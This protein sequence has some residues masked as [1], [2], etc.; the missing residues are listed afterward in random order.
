M[1]ENVFNSWR[2]AAGNVKR[3]SEKN[4]T[5]S[6]WSA[7]NLLWAEAGTRKVRGHKELPELTEALI[8]DPGP[9]DGATRNSIVT[10]TPAS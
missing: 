3:W 6:H 10:E 5:M 7:S 9:T 1:I 8:T 2:D 4:D